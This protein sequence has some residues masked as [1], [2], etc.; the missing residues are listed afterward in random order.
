MASCDRS[1]LEPEAPGDAKERT[2]DSS[3]S[4]TIDRNET[5]KDATDEVNQILPL[6]ALS[7]GSDTK[8]SEQH[9]K[10][11]ETSPIGSYLIQEDENDSQVDDKRQLLNKIQ[12]LQDQLLG[13]EQG[14][15]VQE[16][17]RIFEATWESKL[18][19]NGME[20]ERDEWI[21]VRDMRARSF[22]KNTTEMSLGR[23]WSRQNENNAFLDMM[24]RKEFDEQLLRRRQKWEQSHN[25]VAAQ[26][27]EAPLRMA[28][29]GPGTDTGN[30]IH[31]SAYFDTDL[32]RWNDTPV[33]RNFDARERD[34]QANM[35]DLLRAR[36]ASFS[37]WRALGRQ[38]PPIQV[39]DTNKCARPRLNFVNWT[40]FRYEPFEPAGLSSASAIDILEGEPDSSVTIDHYHELKRTWERSKDMKEV[41]SAN[42]S[43]IQ[44]Q[45]I[46]RVRLNGPQL[47]ETLKLLSEEFPWVIPMWSSRLV[48]IA[49]FRILVYH[50]K[51]IRSRYE[52]MKKR[53]SELNTEEGEA[54]T[55][56]SSLTEAGLQTAGT[57]KSNNK[58][59]SNES[60]QDVDAEDQEHPGDRPQ[61]SQEDAQHEPGSTD[62]PEQEQ[63]ESPTRPADSQEAMEHLGCLIELIDTRII[64]KMESIR[65]GREHKISFRDLWYLFQPGDE[66]IQRDGRQ[67]Y[68]VV[69]VINPE[70]RVSARNFL[71]DYDEDDTTK[72]F[73][74]NCVYVDFDGRRFGP[75]T[76]VFV[77]KSFAAERAVDS[78]EV[79]PL[80]FH[81]TKSPSSEAQQNEDA[82]GWQS[83]RQDLIDRGKRFFRAARM[84][85]VNTFYSGLT[86]AGDEIES[87][88]VIDFETAL[89]SAENIG[90]EIA[91]QIESV[92][93]DANDNASINSS[94]CFIGCEG[95]CCEGQNVLDDSWID[96]QRKAEYVT[97]LVP[98]SF[99]TT[100]LPS[101]AVHPRRLDDTTGDNALTDAEYVLMTNRVFAFILRTRKWG[102]FAPLMLLV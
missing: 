29:F 98:Q 24:G 75:V 82:A 27:E 69:E 92:L 45:P 76:K 91:P 54:P 85:L 80:R 99:T 63:P 89:S 60:S 57:E 37:S 23:D 62:E 88:V 34:L 17:L 93:S 51:A 33:A 61:V 49:P 21:R 47:I 65:D 36:Y 12:Q 43:D 70:H 95:F 97:S 44:T 16:R 66:V 53:F 40:I 6:S 22:I 42:I 84:K 14:V 74:L 30:H 13:I 3:L 8:S 15:G 64:K 41:H 50:E 81:R 19:E 38:G 67:I 35:N 20:K 83:V 59:E 52:S 100:K 5:L 56:H 58:V 28:L 10:P 102:K 86:A 71:I 72:F 2:E 1:A 90:P 55:E 87:Q 96:E 9:Q 32:A 77:I 94:N 68:R 4:P 79:Y 73:K 101:V 18:K 31:A 26:N 46:D 39:E 78:L 11:S 7:G 48:I 25:I